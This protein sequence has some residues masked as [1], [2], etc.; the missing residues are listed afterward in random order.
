MTGLAVEAT[1]KTLYT[2]KETIESEIQR[3]IEMARRKNS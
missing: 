1:M 3:E 2:F